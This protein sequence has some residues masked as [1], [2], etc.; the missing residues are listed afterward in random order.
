MR[1]ATTQEVGQIMK[2]A[3]LRRKR[4]SKRIQHA[5]KVHAYS[6][7]T[8]VRVRQIEVY[9]TDRRYYGRAG[10]RKVLLYIVTGKNAVSGAVTL[11]TTTAE[12]YKAPTQKRRRA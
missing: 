3:Y 10:T 11:Q 5:S 6:A 4:H 1:E 12:H 7:G 8:V 9:A 2:Q